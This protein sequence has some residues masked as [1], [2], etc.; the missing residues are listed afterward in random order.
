MTENIRRVGRRVDL[1]AAGLPRGAVRVAQPPA[2]DTPDPLAHANPVL[3]HVGGDE[4]QQMASLVFPG[5]L[6][7]TST[8]LAVTLGDDSK[9]SYFGAKHTAVVQAGETH[10]DVID[11]SVTVVN[12][13]VYADINDVLEIIESQNLESKLRR[14]LLAAGVAIPDDVTFEQLELL[15]AAA[16]TQG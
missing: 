16:F 12:E 9:E 7:T 8:T 11:R 4:D 5:E 13:T 15:H 2:E 6:L 10:N 3:D 14:E 1:E